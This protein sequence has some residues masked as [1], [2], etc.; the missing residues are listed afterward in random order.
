MEAN[1]QDS[2]RILQ[3]SKN[4]SRGY[5]VILIV[6]IS[7][8]SI[9]GCFSSISVPKYPANWPAFPSIPF[10]PTS[11]RIEAVCCLTGSYAEK[12]ESLSGAPAS[13]A[14][15]LFG[16]GRSGTISGVTVVTFEGPQNGYLQ[17]SAWSDNTLIET[18]KL[19]NWMIHVDEGRREVLSLGYQRDEHPYRR[20]ECLQNGAVALFPPGFPSGTYGR[21]TYLFRAHDGSLMFKVVNS[22]VGFVFIPVAVQYEVSWYRFPPVS[23]GEDAQ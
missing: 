21:E 11:T 8:T 19:S 20:Y 22:G 6:L 17:I 2:S 7:A 16:H 9:S 4:A 5:I 23:Q 3:S 14:K 12:G 18:L 15:I 13:L 10:L 1:R